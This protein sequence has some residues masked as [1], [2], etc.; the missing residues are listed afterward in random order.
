MGRYFPSH[1]FRTDPAALLGVGITIDLGRAAFI[2]PQLR[3][4][5]APGAAGENVNVTLLP[6]VGLGWRF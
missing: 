3:T 2:R 6:S 4:Y 5:I 1:D